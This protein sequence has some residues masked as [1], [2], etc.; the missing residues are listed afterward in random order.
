MYARNHDE[1]IESFEDE[2]DLEPEFDTDPDDGL[3]NAY[4]Q[5]F[6]AGERD[7]REAGSRTENPYAL[8]TSLDSYELWEDGYADA[9]GRS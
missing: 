8:D 5:G 7:A 9:G 6:R 3:G 4:E 1:A 2:A